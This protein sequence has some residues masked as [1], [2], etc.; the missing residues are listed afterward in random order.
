MERGLRLHVLRGAIFQST[1]IVG[2]L[3]VTPKIRGRIART[4][5]RLAWKCQMGLSQKACKN[6]PKQQQKKTHKS[7]PLPRRPDETPLYCCVAGQALTDRHTGGKLGGAT[8]WWLQLSQR[9]RTQADSW[10]PVAPDATVMEA[11]G[12][13]FHRGGQSAAQGSGH[14][15]SQPGKQ[16]PDSHRSSRKDFLCK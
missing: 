9:S 13:V 14:C 7:V 10:P 11:R 15:S 8:D 3:K 1:V 2:S 6:K 12:I 16:A 5:N 4:V